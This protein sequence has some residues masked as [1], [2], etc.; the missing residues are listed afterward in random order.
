MQINQIYDQLKN[1][2]RNL[3]N[4]KSK[5]N[6]L[7]VDKLVAVSVDL[8]KLNDLVKNDVVKKDAYNAKIKDIKDKIAD[9][10]ELATTTTT[11]NAKINEAKN[12]IPSITNLAATAA[13]NAKINEVQNEIPNITNLATTTALTAVDNKMLEIQSK[14]LTTT[15][16]LVKFKIKLLLIM[17]IIN[18]LLLKNLIS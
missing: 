8:S 9:I 12:E 2:P 6:K 15:Q 18:M 11:L 5:V 17:I 3:S 1:V 4:L 10:T 14:K 16:K 7:D 13:F